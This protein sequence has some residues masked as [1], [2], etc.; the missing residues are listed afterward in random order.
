MACFEC[1]NIGGVTSCYIVSYGV[2]YVDVKLATVRMIY[3]ALIFSIVH[4]LIIHI[5]YRKMYRKI[6]R[7]RFLIC[8][9]HRILYTQYSVIYN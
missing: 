5:M 8:I 6:Y 9:M 2:R 3:G 1:I 7:I 4:V